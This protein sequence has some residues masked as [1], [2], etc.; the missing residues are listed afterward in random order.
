MGVVYL[1]GT[2]IGGVVIKRASETGGGG[3]IIYKG[4]FFEGEE[5]M[6]VSLKRQILAEEPG[7]RAVTACRQSSRC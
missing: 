2:R 1:E 7:E 4:S 3:G 6:M 5:N